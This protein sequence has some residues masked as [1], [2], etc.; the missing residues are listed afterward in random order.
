MQTFA[1]RL[2]RYDYHDSAKDG[3]LYCRCGTV[4]PAEITEYYRHYHVLG[5]T[6]CRTPLALVDHPLSQ[7]FEI[8]DGYPLSGVN[9]PLAA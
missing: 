8:F 4:A 7:E 2:R 6:R 9:N 5:C 1:P 3:A